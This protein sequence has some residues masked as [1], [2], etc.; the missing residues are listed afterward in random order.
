MHSCYQHA[1]LH[2]LLATSLQ[3]V[4]MLAGYQHPSPAINSCLFLEL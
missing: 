2:H 1:D 3:C 4:D